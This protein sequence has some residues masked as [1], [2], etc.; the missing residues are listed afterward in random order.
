MATS[1]VTGS[2]NLYF[3][4]KLSGDEC[5][6]HSSWFS[7]ITFKRSI[8]REISRSS[9][10]LRFHGYDFSK[11][12]SIENGASLRNVTLSCLTDNATKYFDFIVIGSGVAGLRYALEVSKYGSVAVITKAEPHESNTNYAQGGVSAVLCPLD[13]VE[14]HMRDTIVAGAYL[15]DEETVRVVC[16]EGPDRV[17]ELIAIGASFDHG[18]DG[19]LHLAREGGHSHHRIVHAADMTGREIE[20]ALL[21]AVDGNPGIFMF[22]HHFAIDLL[23]SQDGSEIYCHGVDT[24]NTETQQV[25]R[26]ISKVTLLASGGAGHIYPTT[27]NPPVA[28]GDG[29]AMAHR[30]QAVISNMEFVQFHPTALAD[31]GLPIRPTKARENAFLITEAVRGDGGILYNQAME[32][33]MPLYDERAELAP[34]DV[35]AR[36]IDDQL[37]QRKEKYVLLDISHKPKAEILSHFPNIAAE[38]L[39]Y[40]LDITREPMP[41]VPAAHYMCGGVRAGLHGE[42]NIRGL[43]VAGEVACTGLHG[44]NRLASNSLLEA[45]VFAQRAVQ[46]SVDHMAEMSLEFSVS[47]A[48]ARPVLPISLKS[49]VLDDITRRTKQTREEMQVIMWEYVGIVRSTSRLKTAEWRLNELEEEWEDYLNR[50]GW[51]PT[52][53][54]LEAC[55]MRN[56][57]CCAKLVVSSALARH[58]SR[59]LHFTIDFPHLEES[60]RQPTIIF[61]SSPMKVSWSSQQVHKQYHF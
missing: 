26:F 57:F 58:E 36:S 33:F 30:A 44:A 17:K 61:P 59:G 18:D 15:C 50:Q 22:E 42:T 20:R 55:K 56:L 29:M 14:N 5:Y 51:E 1:L 25:V 60:K 52:M 45:L 35:V 39:H 11:A 41:V 46:P 7:G 21:K 10:F 49:C 24:L 31:E 6:R 53:V 19:N 43:Y 8:H 40:G 23:T 32:R 48:W 28:T 9:K 27:T 4:V 37:K 13:S 34:R 16:T 54:G 2:A 38:C 12:P 3:G 47:N